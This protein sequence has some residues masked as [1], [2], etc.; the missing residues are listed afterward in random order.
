MTHPLP[1]HLASLA[2]SQRGNLTLGQMQE[3]GLSASAVRRLLRAGVL[4][5]RGRRVVASALAPPS[6]HAELVGLVLDI[7]GRVWASGP[8]AAALHG[9]DGFAL[10]PPFHLTIER[11]RQVRRPG[12]VVHTAE[13][14]SP[15]DLRTVEGIPC[16]AG[17][18]TLI[19]LAGDPRVDDAALT[20]A[21]ASALRDLSTTEDHL[22][23]RIAALR[24]KGRHGIPRLMAVIES[25]EAARGAHS[26]LEREFL[27]LLDDAG[28]PL[29]ETQ[30]VLA[31]ADGR[32]VRVDCHFA[33]TPVVVEVLGYEWHRTRAQMDRDAVRANALLLQGRS[34]YQ[35]TYR[36]VTETPN[37]VVATVREALA[38]VA[39]GSV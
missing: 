23:R 17:A 28:I 3:A 21:L 36:Q 8:T 24:G 13:L 29:P 19:D 5:R 27:R 15:I 12:H 34:P 10:A 1:P 2:V 32:L 22:H 7:G 11:G 30:V 26:W 38:G 37:A 4:V 31:E 14:M 9:F 39:L 18:R 6:A 33:G 35:F 25:A 20:V 16:T